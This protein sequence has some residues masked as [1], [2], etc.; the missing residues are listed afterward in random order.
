[1]VQWYG[2]VVSDQRLHPSLY[3]TAYFREATHSLSSLQ[4]MRIYDGHKRFEML[5]LRWGIPTATRERGQVSLIS[6]EFH[7]G[8]R[9]LRCAEG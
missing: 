9:F 8:W 7:N 6:E 4:L 3:P 5:E 1:M 2:G